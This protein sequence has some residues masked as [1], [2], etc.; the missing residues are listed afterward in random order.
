MKPHSAPHS[1]VASA[2]P[3][4]QPVRPRSIR[5]GQ[6][7]LHLSI[8]AL[9]FAVAVAHAQTTEKKTLTLAGAKRAI[10]GAVEYAR[11]H[12]APGG[13]IAV[14]DDAGHL[15]ALE[16]LDDTF[17]AASAVS[18]G[19]ARTAARFQKP[20]RFF[21]EAIRNGRTPLLAMDDFTPLQGGVLITV[22]GHI[23]GAIGVS[24]AAS[25]QQDEEVA[26][27]G[28]AAVETKKP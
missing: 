15:I 12:N 17:P 24:G 4:R 26:L 9:W 8:L 20:T 23:V 2:V 27:A 6:R 19:K 7:T 28:S 14:V 3:S 18:I 1:V 10:A 22:D 21:E 16:R 5:W 11:Q 25:A 13:A